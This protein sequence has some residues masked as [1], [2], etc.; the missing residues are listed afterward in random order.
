MNI[1][2]SAGPAARHVP[3][4][5]INLTGEAPAVWTGGFVMLDTTSLEDQQHLR[6]VALHVKQANSC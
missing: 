3:K 1:A 5:H 4:E 2:A 6:V